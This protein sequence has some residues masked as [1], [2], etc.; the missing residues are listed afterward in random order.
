MFSKQAMS[1]TGAIFLM[2][3]AEM[4]IAVQLERRTMPS[5]CHNDSNMQLNEIRL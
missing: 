2:S 3:G 1:L 5:T 4:L